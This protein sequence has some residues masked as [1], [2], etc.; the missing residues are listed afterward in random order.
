MK[1]FSFVLVLLL[2]VCNAWGTPKN[3]IVLIG[4]G[5]GPSH[6]A[7]ARILSVGKSG[8]LAMDSMPVTGFVTTY[9]ANSLITDSAA[10]ATALAT[11]VKANNHVVGLSP[12]GQ[13]LKTI[14]EA[15]SEIGKST[16]LV[17]T[18]PITD[19]TPAGFGSHVKDRSEQP[20]I[21]Q[22]LL[23][24]QIDVLMGGGKQNFIPQSVDGSARVDTCDLLKDAASKGYDVVGT[25]EDLK[26]AHGSK[27]L[28]LFAPSYLTTIAPE[29]PLSVMASKAID[30]LS[31]NKKGFF[32]MVE[33]GQID[34]CS[35]GNNFDGMVAQA[36]E[37]DH[38]VAKALE[39]AKKDGNT[40]VIVTADHET[41]GLT[42]LLDDNGNIKPN[43]STTGHSGTVV[44]L[45]AFGPDSKNFAGLMDNT[46]IPKTIAKEWG[47]SIGLVNEKGASISSAPQKQL[48]PA[49]A[50]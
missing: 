47:L 19:A 42:L 24:N 31:K 36:V 32:L 46:Y 37:F 25:Y 28:G 3:V 27:I 16:G 17:T 11:G 4:D 49:L 38:A 22:Q 43:W 15:A 44:P 7:A 18:C 41:G 35:H 40:L 26:A 30:T 33:G 29:P 21:A 2:A 20:E 34:I 10:A 45:Y 8:R 50:G 23:A 13:I 48:V 12:D 5:M 39:F 1:R 6:V 14:L 9:S